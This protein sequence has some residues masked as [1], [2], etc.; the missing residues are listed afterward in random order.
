M[1]RLKTFDAEPY[2]NARANGR[3][4]KKAAENAAKPLSKKFW[5]CTRVDSAAG[6]CVNKWKHER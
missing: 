4:R 6:S 3:K 5:M 1:P 2:R